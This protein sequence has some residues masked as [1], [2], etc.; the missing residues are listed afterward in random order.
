MHVIWRQ[1]RDHLIPTTSPLPQ[2]LNAIQLDQ[3]DSDIAPSNLCQRG[4][5]NMGMTQLW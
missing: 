1:F 5:L 2:L 3:R 4:K